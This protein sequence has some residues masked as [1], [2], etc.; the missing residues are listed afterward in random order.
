MQTTLCCSASAFAT[1]L[2]MLVGLIIASNNLQYRGEQFAASQIVPMPKISMA[3]KEGPWPKCIGM[4]GEACVDY[5]ESN[6][7]GLTLVI[8]REGSMVTQ[9]FR[10]DRVRIWV[11]ADDIVYATPSRG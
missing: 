7:D 6:T 3:T 5:I 10:T 2:L 8:V 4:T 9:D 1:M 11:D